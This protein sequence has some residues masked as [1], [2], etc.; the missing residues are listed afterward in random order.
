[1]VARVSGTGLVGRIGAG[2][3]GTTVVVPASGMTRILGV[4][5][6]SET[7]RMTV[8]VPASGT[9][10]VGMTGGVLVGM[11]G[12]VQAGTTVAVPAS[13]MGLVGMTG[14]AQD[15][16]PAGGMTQIEAA[17]LGIETRSHEPP[18]PR[19]MKILITRR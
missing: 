3:V 5:R 7:A 6:V 19:S 13:G 15:G 16:I 12:G 11:T 8:V 9:G 14:G 1:M 4:A 10:L 18:R 17:D 2:L